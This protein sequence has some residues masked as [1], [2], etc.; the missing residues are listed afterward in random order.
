MKIRPV[1]P[2][3]FHADRQTEDGHD[4]SNSRISQFANAPKSSTFCPQYIYMF[5]MYLR[6]KHRIHNAQLLVFIVEVVSV[7]CAVRTGSL[8]KVD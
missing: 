6:K 8:N 2:E 7:Y 1:G 4:K 3:L 5:C